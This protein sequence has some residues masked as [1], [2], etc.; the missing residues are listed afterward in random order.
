[1]SWAT[2]DHPSHTPGAMLT[3]MAEQ[4]NV[5]PPAEQSAPPAEGDQAP[6]RREWAGLLLDVA[7]VVAA[8]ILALTVADIVFDGRLSRPVRSALRRS[9][10][11][12]G[13]DDEH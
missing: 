13:G 9:D 1:M 7:A 4:E 6:P 12:P 3:A 2:M 8:V 5:S 10:G 11:D